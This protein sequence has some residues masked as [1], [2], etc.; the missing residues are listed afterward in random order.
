MIR[1][2]VVVAT[3]LAVLLAAA[4]PSVLATGT[5]IGGFRVI[6]SPFT[7]DAVSTRHEAGIR[8]TLLHPARVTLTIEEPTSQVVLHMKT[9]VA[10]AAGKYKWSW[11]GGR[12]GGAL[13]ADGDY[14]VH[15]VVAGE[16]GREE[17]TLPVRKG[18]PP[19]YPANPGAITV[20]INPG[21]GGNN[22]GALNKYLAEKTVNLDIGLRL[23]RLLQA[24]GINVVMTRDTDVHVPD[25]EFDVNGDGVIGPTKRGGDDWDGLAYRLDIGNMARADLHIF[26]HNNGSSD[27]RARGTE[28][29]TGLER[30]W[31]PEG[32][33]FA[34]AMQAGQVGQLDTFRSSTYYPIDAGVKNGA[35]FYTL[36]P[37]DLINPPIEPRPALQ[38]TVLT[39]SLFCSNPV[40]RDLLLKG[41]VREA[42]AIGMYLGIRDYLAARD[43]GI[44]YELV[45]G[46]ANVA[47][48]APADYQV[49]VT[50]TGNLTSAGW[51][52]QL[53][54][55]AA[56]PFYDGSE[57]IGDLM[58]TVAI[59]DGLAPGQ[60]T[61]LTVNA[62]APPTAG[63]WL[64]KADVWTLE[65]DRPY[66]SQR[67]VVS[68]QVPL[69]TEP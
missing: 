59:P 40:E 18:M 58:G 35:R 32:I 42:L 51:Q 7:S 63:A 24:A 4:P 67:G 69:T 43:Y 14:V 13:A 31:T 50:N 12:D 44:R 47:P 46:P 11:A 26:N 60:S 36:S 23:R 62:T 52:L 15:L 34:T 8:L 33:A 21:H 22:S 2:G 57:A 65:V 19:I 3:A 48:G 53:H 5:V 9:G 25:P 16:F 56:V 54:S 30:S 28:T 68:M 49:K 64:V 39:E 37:Y 55:V 1:A 20:L 61:T 41:K 17:H 38:P 66:L 29:F 10:L 27:S 45:D 6:A